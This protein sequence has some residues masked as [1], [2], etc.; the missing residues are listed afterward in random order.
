MLKLK[1]QCKLPCCHVDHCKPITRTASSVTILNWQVRS[2]LFNTYKS[3]IPMSR[4]CAIEKVTLAA[5]W[6]AALWWVDCLPLVCQRG[7]TLPYVTLSAVVR[8]GYTCVYRG[9]VLIKIRHS[10]FLCIY[11]REECYVKSCWGTIAF[12]TTLSRTEVS[13]QLTA[14][15]NMEIIILCQTVEVSKRLVKHHH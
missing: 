14:W 4:M 13:M 8:S 1:T 2:Y 12:F 6:P 9:R 15:A 11:C 5:Y 3:W 7:T 10:I